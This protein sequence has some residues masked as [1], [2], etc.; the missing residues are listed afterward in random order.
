LAIRSNTRRRFDES[1]GLPASEQNT[2]LLSFHFGPA[3]SRSV[4]W[5]LLCALS[6][7]TALGT[8]RSPGSA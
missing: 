5:R 6:A 2:S 4:A 3:A 1:I 8:A 7:T